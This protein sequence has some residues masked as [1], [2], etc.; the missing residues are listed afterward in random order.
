MNYFTAAVD[1]QPMRSTWTHAY[2][3]I[4]C[5]SGAAVVVVVE[6]PMGDAVEH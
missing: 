1:Q 2:N 6:Q 3:I 4:C 5:D